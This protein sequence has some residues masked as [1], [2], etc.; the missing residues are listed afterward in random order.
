M[1]IYPWNISLCHYLE[2]DIL[3]QARYMEYPK[4]R[5]TDGV[6]QWHL[7]GPKIEDLTKEERIAL[8]KASWDDILKPTGIIK[9][10]IDKTRGVSCHEDWRFSVNDYLSGW[11]VVG[12]EWTD[13][14]GPSPDQVNIGFR[15]ETKC[16]SEICNEWLYE[17]ISVNEEEGIV[18]VKWLTKEE[19]SEKSI[20][21]LARQPKVWINV[22]GYVPPGEVGAAK[23]GGGLFII[24]TKL[25]VIFGAL[26]PY[27]KEYFV[28]GGKFKDWTRI[29]VRGVKVPILDPETKKPIPGKYEM[30]WKCMIPSDQKPYT[31]SKR[32]KE[33][34]WYPPKDKF[35]FPPKYDNTPE[36]KEWIE[37]A[38][39]YWKKKPKGTEK[40]SKVLDFVLHVITAMGPPHV[41]GIPNISWHLRIK[42]PTKI[43][44]W[45]LRSDPL[46]EYPLPSFEE[47]FPDSRY[48]DY[49][50]KLDADHPMNPF[51]FKR[52]EANCIIE[53]RGKVRYN[54]IQEKPEIIE[55]EF[56]GEFLKGKWHLIQEEAKSDIYT[57]DKLSK[58][59][60]SKKQFVLH[61]HE[62]PIDSGKYHIDIR[63][64]MDGY[65]DEFNIYN[66]EPWTLKEEERVKA[67]RKVCYQ[68]KDWFIK[69]GKG[70]KRR[71]GNV[72]TKIDVLDSGRVDVIE[73]NPY[74]MSMIFYGNKI[75]GYYILKKED[76]QWFF[77]K[78]RLPKPKLAVREGDPI[79]GT[80]YSPFKIEKK[81]GW[82]YYW[83]HIYD[84][85]K[86]TRCVNDKDARELYLKGISIPDTVLELNICLV[87][88]PGTLPLA[89]LASIKVSDT[90]SEEEI[91]NWIKR[92]GLHTWSRTMIRKERKTQQQLN[93][94]NDI[95]KNSEGC[96]QCQKK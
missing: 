19:L 6:V 92:N 26:K 67:H 73:R 44:S 60:L 90:V 58:E 94:M 3:A 89:R 17:V 79:T 41:R 24:K 81:K 84:I 59:Q 31:L 69:E 30:M 42:T 96:I 57:L 74:F 27:F 63:I 34:G 5:I 12:L 13:K 28:K 85:K 14:L 95:K 35:P 86:F 71:V 7:R 22:R 49:E 37:R 43:R 52:L 21:E 47:V 72:W 62:V 2:R 33:K 16:F 9:R 88:R 68:V 45:N 39:E 56:K 23:E 54:V 38:K 1:E 8:A 10:A 36:F 18:N 20:E 53:D 15:C 11:S 25:K 51:G 91:T 48:F 65:L 4:K 77:I 50:G 32:A 76:N 64:L 61:L 70:I 29:I 55:L 87:P 40:M 66:L 82:N 93:L 80:Y 83:V 46:R 75:K 78:S